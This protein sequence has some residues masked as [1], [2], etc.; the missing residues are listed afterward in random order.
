MQSARISTYATALPTTPVFS[1]ELLPRHLPSRYITAPGLRRRRAHGC[2]GRFRDRRM[3]T[4]M[5]RSVEPSTR[6]PPAVRSGGRF[7][8]SNADCLG[9]FALTREIALRRSLASRADPETFA[10]V[11]RCL[12]AA[13]SQ[14]TYAHFPGRRACWQLAL[15]DPSS[16]FSG[17]LR[18]GSKRSVDRKFHSPRALSADLHRGDARLPRCRSLA[19]PRTTKRSWSETPAPE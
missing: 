3:K 10:P 18:I 1:S 11:S 14:Q 13:M 17:L 2:H 16:D 8:R 19:R 9:F 12:L 6:R 7:L 4:R 15:I 5:R